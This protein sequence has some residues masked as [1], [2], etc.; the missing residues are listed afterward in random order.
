[1]QGVVIDVDR[2]GACSP[3]APRPHR[4]RLGSSRSRIVLTSACA[5][6]RSRFRSRAVS[7]E[8]DRFES[9]FNVMQAVER[10][11]LA[12]GRLAAVLDRRRRGRQPVLMDPSLHRW[13]PRSTAAS[14]RRGATSTG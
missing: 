7:F 9:R 6:P 5:T 3:H 11:P 2:V 4:S 12:I 10:Y 13:M 8:G 1:M 14:S